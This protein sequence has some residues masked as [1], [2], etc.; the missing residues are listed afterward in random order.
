[1]PTICL[2]LFLFFSI[3]S[4][5]GCCTIN[6]GFFPLFP[7]PLLL[8][9]FCLFSYV[10]TINLCV[11]LFSADLLSFCSLFFAWVVVALFTLR[12]ACVWYIGTGS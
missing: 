9:F 12:L 4:L 7:L 6:L 10:S 11:P 2:T 5:A 1:L 8:F 3:S